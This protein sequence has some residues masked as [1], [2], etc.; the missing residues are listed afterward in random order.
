MKSRCI[1][2]LLF[3][4]IYPTLGWGQDSKFDEMKPISKKQAVKQLSNSLELNK[5]DREVAA[6]YMALAKELYAQ[7]D[8]AKA[9]NNLQQAVQLYSKDKELQAEAYRQLA[10]AQEAQSK[11][12]AA[13]TNYAHAAKTTK[14]KV[15]REINENDANRL[16]NRSDLKS[17]S[18][19]LQRNID[20]SN[21]VDNKDVAVVAHQQKAQ[22]RREMNDPEGAVHELKKALENIQDKP[23]EALK[24]KQEIAKTYTEDE[25]YE[26]AIDLNQSL[27]DESQKSSNPKVEIEQ[28]KNLAHTY[29]VAKDEQKGVQVLEQAYRLAIENHQTMEA[30]NT[31]GELTN[32]YIENNNPSAALNAYRDFTCQLDTL[33]RSDSTLIEEKFFQLHEERIKRLENERALKDELIVRT[34]L[35]NYVLLGAIVLILIFL[36]LIAKALYSISKKNK[37]IALQSLRREMNPHFIFNSLNSVNQFIAQN[38][39][40]EANKY[41]SSYSRLMRNMMENSNKDFISLSTELDQLKEYLELEHMRFKDK[42]T[43][44]I[45]MDNT[46]DPDAVYIPNMIVQPQLENAIWHGLRYKEE[47]GLL[48]LLIEKKQKNIVITV[49][50]NGIGIK[51]SQDLKTKH[52][53][54][55]HHSRGLTNTN[56]RI[57]L[58]NELY[59]IPISIQIIEK[60]GENKSGVVVVLKF[61]L[62]DKKIQ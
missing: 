62:I 31:L 14:K 45:Q 2:I 52:Q 5:S 23:G 11:F 9:E 12:D 55:H 13:I 50:D 22:I 46:L 1:Y 28:L 6:D 34:N 56:E 40:L 42:F 47:N 41:L 15:F 59:H 35:F 3:L 53:K 8:Y 37:K 36:I 16:K 10:R 60:E 21:R 24:I 58:L 27:V 48:M 25:Q 39:E 61:P 49:E 18:S 20:L 26:K 19:Y 4:C 30:K 54:Q 32:Y 57:A 44:E 17:Q 7:A 33:I 51:R 43:Y 38:N 29:F